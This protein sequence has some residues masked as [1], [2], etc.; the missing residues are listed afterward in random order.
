MCDGQVCVSA[1]QW[2]IPVDV[3]DVVCFG[4][5]SAG[6]GRHVQCVRAVC[7]ENV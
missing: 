1:S 4:N 3:A 5:M 7:S 2:D 6:A